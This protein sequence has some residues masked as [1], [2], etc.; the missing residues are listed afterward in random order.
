MEAAEE[1]RLPESEIVAQVSYVL[2]CL[3]FLSQLRATR[4]FYSTLTF[5]AMDTTS[6]A[7]SRILHMLATHPEVQEKLREEILVAR[8]EAGGDLE[9]D[10]LVELPY[11]EAVCRETLRVYVPHLLH[12]LHHND[13]NLFLPVILL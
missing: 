5:A 3:P 7:L 9:Y 8:E 10:S 12:Y 6:N 2:T 1:D 11:L 4:P 13:A